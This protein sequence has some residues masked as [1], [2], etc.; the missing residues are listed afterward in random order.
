MTSHVKPT[1][2]PTALPRECGQR[3]S[4]RPTS[5]PSGSRRARC[6]STPTTCSARSCRS[7]ATSKAAG[8]A[9]WARKSSP[10]TSRP[11]RSSSSSSL[12]F[13]CERRRRVSPQPGG[14][15]WSSGTEDNADPA[16]ASDAQ[17]DVDGARN[18]YASFFYKQRQDD[19][20]LYHLIIDS[21]ALPIDACVDIVIR[22]ARAHIGGRDAPT[23]PTAGRSNE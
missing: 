21:T 10:I 4:R 1:T 5:S 18:D 2:L 19:A 6:G 13:L 12:V 22:A 16:T 14:D 9:R 7:A 15:S 17:R 3:T 23:T 8:A 11:S 20:R